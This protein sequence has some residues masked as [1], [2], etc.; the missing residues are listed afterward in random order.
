M[1]Q[2]NGVEPLDQHVQANG[3]V[4]RPFQYM[5]SKLRA[6]DAIA[7][8]SS[9]L[10]D[11]D[12]YVVDLFTGSTVVAQAFALKGCRVAA[13]DALQFPVAAARALLGIGRQQV[14]LLDVGK[15]LV[16]MATRGLGVSDF[17]GWIDAED[18]ALAAGDGEAVL[19][20]G[21]SVP[22]VW[23]TIKAT[24]ALRAT[25][26]RVADSAGSPASTATPVAATHYAGTYFGI[27]Q[28]VMIDGLRDAVEIMSLSGW[29]R[30]VCLLAIAH[31]MSC[32]AFT[33]GKHFAQPHKTDSQ[34]DLS[35]HRKRVI[36]DRNIDVGQAFLGALAEIQAASHYSADTH[37]AEQ[38]PFEELLLRPADH[39]ISMIYADPPYTAQ[40]YSRFYH[41][42]E[43]ILRGVV[44][45]LQMQRGRVTAGIYPEDKFK[46]RF[47]S[48][49]DAKSAFI[50]LFALSEKWRAP[51]MISYAASASGQS[52][53][54]RM[55]SLDDIVEGMKR[56]GFQDV[57]VVTLEHN[58]RQLN[59][60]RVAVR[61]RADH[62]YLV[63]GKPKC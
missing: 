24:G 23:R 48:K 34:K 54:E 15:V 9:E 14:K 39:S 11:S 59:H 51:L 17:R 55:V 2:V 53:N 60:G 4:F 36:S 37:C 56:R 3:S 16:S 10:I 47:C 40:Q 62:E 29:L 42:P 35:F 43:T 25:L 12:G 49:R 31:V 63:V 57:E 20:V 38:L 30:D 26:Q 8:A 58:Y 22:Q 52:G 32:A 18:S 41:V 21:A 61:G 1:P 7:D 33:P 27:R 45:K 19:K 5:G 44:P 28:A 46:S 13:Y 6:L 50:D